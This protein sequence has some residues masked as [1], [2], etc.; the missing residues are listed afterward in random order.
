MSS[1]SD[2]KT[3]A[4]ALIGEHTLCEASLTLGVAGCTLTIR[5]NAPALIEQLRHYFAEALAEP[6]AEHMELL[7][8]ER[9]CVD[10][11]VDF[12]DW[13]REPGK[14]GRKDSYRELQ[15]ARLIRKVRTGMVF[16]QSETARI[17]AGPCLQ[18]DNQVINFV[19][20]QCMN[21]LQ[22]R[23]WYICHAAGL[24]HQGRALGMAG[25]S[26][27][28][29]STLML[30]LMDRPDVNYL[31]NDRLFLQR[32]G[33]QVAA[34]GIPK[35]PR[36]NPG[37][38][39]GNPSLHCLVS[40]EQLARWA[41]MPLDELWHLEEKYDVLVS[42]VY[43]NGRM[44]PQAPLGA[45]VVLNW[46]RDSD[47]SPRLER[48]DLAQRPDLLSAIMK[49]PGPFYQ[50]PDGHFLMDTTAL[51]PQPYLHTLQDVPVYEARGGVDFDALVPQ[52]LKVLA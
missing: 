41:A 36:I 34:V 31:T 46:Q 17:A 47:E 37:T 15:D 51:D 12:V 1:I 7:A 3:A 13:Q 11:G 4:Q 23:Q 42:Q 28:G 52:C 25:F 50:Y 27:G 10:L 38:I 6:G 16:L 40:D 8:I 2:A 22:H 9:E 19:N 33:A 29:K 43:G 39:V 32:D 20:A 48:V 24:V 26:G 49:S 21:W 30:R 44:T 45:F 35:L 14:P 5:S 18:Y